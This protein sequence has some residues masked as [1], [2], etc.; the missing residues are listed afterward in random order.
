MLVHVLQCCK[1][2]YNYYSSF[3]ITVLILYI[4]LLLLFVLHYHYII[5]NI[6]FSSITTIKWDVTIIV[7]FL[8]LL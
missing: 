3:G 6:L 8:L 1:Y 7:I 4:D 2:I 5:F